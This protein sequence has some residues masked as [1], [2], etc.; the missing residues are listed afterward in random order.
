MTLK[1]N[2]PWRISLTQ[3]PLPY[4]SQIVGETSLSFM[5]SSDHWA[6]LS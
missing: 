3:L 4:D 2:F 6:I 1:G 5:K